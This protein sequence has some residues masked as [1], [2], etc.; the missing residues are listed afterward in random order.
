LLGFC[1]HLEDVSSVCRPRHVSSN[2]DTRHTITRHSN[3]GVSSRFMNGDNSL[4]TSLQPVYNRGILPET[5][6]YRTQDKP[7]HR[8]FVKPATYD[9]SGQW[10][11]YLSHFE[12]VSLLNKWDEIE[13]GLYLAAS[14]RGLA[15]GL[16]GNQPT[17]ERQSYSKLVKALQ[18]RFSPLNQTELYRTQ[19]RE[20]KQR[21][22]EG[23]PKLGQDIRRL[24]NLAY[25]TAPDDVRG[26]LA[27]EQ[28]LDG[29]HN[30][31]MR[32]KIKQTRPACLNWTIQRAVE[33]EAYYKAEKRRTENI[34]TMEQQ[35]VAQASNIDRHHG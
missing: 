24:V 31:E 9:W 25:P 2:P 10:N 26:I 8:N 21:A 4:P 22:S 18:D 28:F 32:I 6:R 3:D 7:K 17:G 13:K 27:S 1:Q 5:D 30:S 33:S 14:L 29:L 15:Q 23:L 34:T 20:R 16:L 12:P 11:D 35:D 19:L